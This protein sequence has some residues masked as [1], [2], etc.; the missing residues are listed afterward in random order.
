M[1]DDVEAILKQL[2]PRG[3][4][5][6]LRT[7]VL[8]AVAEHLPNA[9]ATSD[10]PAAAYLFRWDRWPAVVVAASVLLALGLNLWVARLGDARLAAIYGPQPVPRYITE[11]ADTIASVTDAETGRRVQEQLLAAQ[12]PRRVSME[13]ALRNYEHMLNA[14]LLVEKDLR[15]E[16]VQ[17]DTEMDRDRPRCT[18]GDTSYYQRRSG[19]DH[20]FTA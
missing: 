12:R 4:G 20:R 3:A 6:T 17:E 7:S 13:Q 18:G 15:H 11:I 14:I 5:P 2:T 8:D 1:S 16:A 19:P 9:R 10:R